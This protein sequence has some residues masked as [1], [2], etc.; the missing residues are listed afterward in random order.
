MEY[1]F[2]FVSIFL[3]E[4]GPFIEN[5]DFLAIAVFIAPLVNNETFGR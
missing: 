3:W 2:S 5:T 4:M 1:Y